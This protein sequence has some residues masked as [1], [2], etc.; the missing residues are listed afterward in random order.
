MEHFIP[1]ANLPSDPPIILPALKSRKLKAIVP[2]VLT[3]A[4]LAGGLA[5]TSRLVSQR[6]N[7]ATEASTAGLVDLSLTTTTANPAP[8][9][10]FNVNLLINTNSAVVSAANITVA[11][12]TTKLQLLSITPGPFFS[13]GFV[14]GVHEMLSQTSIATAGQGK[15]VVGV[16][17]LIALPSPVPTNPCLTKTGAGIVTT[18]VFKVLPATSGTVALTFAPTP[19]ITAVGQTSSV[20]GSASPLSL[21]ITPTASGY[22]NVNLFGTQSPP[23]GSVTVG[24]VAAVVLGVKFKPAVN[25]R[26]IGVRFHKASTNTGT[27]VGKLWTSNGSQ[28]A[29][30]N[31]TGETASGWQQ[32]NFATPVTVT[33]NTTYVAS[34]SVPVGHWTVQTFPPTNIVNGPLTAPV[35]S[36]GVYKYGG[37]SSFPSASVNANYFVDVMFSSP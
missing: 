35:G 32:V 13:Q 23:T 16:P 27:H 8:G 20:L 29:T 11:Y 2:A 17:C 31:F 12:P 1:P 34:V 37:A 33:A 19:T 24:D 15:L 26:I 28:L 25:G 3:L 14:S 7:L 36:N 22:V 30:A 5:V 18:Y 21:N 4:L 9:S 10:T 6:Q